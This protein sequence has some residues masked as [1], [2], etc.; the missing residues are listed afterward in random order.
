M[1]KAKKRSKQTVKKKSAKGKRHRKI[2]GSQTNQPFEQDAKRRIGQFGGAGE[3]PI[4]K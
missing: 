3:P 2:S 1:A 4:M